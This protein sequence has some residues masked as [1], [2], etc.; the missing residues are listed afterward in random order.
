MKGKEVGEVRCVFLIEHFPDQVY[1]PSRDDGWF[2]GSEV[3]WLNLPPSVGARAIAHSNCRA[4]TDLVREN[5]FEERLEK[6]KCVMWSKCILFTV[7]DWLNVPHALL[8]PLNTQIFTFLT[9]FNAGMLTAW[10]PAKYICFCYEYYI[11][12]GWKRGKLF[13]LILWDKKF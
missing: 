9:K 12:S 2:G 7:T 6:S 4:E 10:H 3:W 1:Y 5:Q 8:C 11:F 13:C